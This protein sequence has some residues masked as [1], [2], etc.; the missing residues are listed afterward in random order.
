MSLNLHVMHVKA[1]RSRLAPPRTQLAAGRPPPTTELATPSPMA[2]F[3]T[4]APSPS[5]ASAQ[6]EAGA[7]HQQAEIQGGGGVA[8]RIWGGEAEPSPPPTRCWLGAAAR[9]PRCQLRLSACLVVGGTR[10]TGTMHFWVRHRLQCKT[11][12]VFAY[13]I[14]GCFTVWVTHFWV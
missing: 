14:G 8:A 6:A 9:P 4:A 7:K 12:A 13:P 3:I 2:S 5:P 11:G 10:A 1:S